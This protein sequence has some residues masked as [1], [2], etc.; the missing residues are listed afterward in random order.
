MNQNF[1]AEYQSYFFMI[2]GLLLMAASFFLKTRNVNLKQ[3]G[4]AVEGIIFEQ[5]YE[6][7]SS[8]LKDKI[9]VRFV[10]ENKEWITKPITS[11]FPNVLLSAVQ[12]R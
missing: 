5:G 11:G 6:N 9:V 1:L 12:S 2:V 3:D 4:I 8:D 7:G 10:T